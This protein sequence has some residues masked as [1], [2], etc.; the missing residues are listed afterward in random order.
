VITWTD[1]TGKTIAA[2]GLGTWAIGGPVAAGDDDLGWAEQR[3]LT[4]RPSY[5]QARTAALA[6]WWAPCSD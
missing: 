2:M 6:E 5:K 4:T 1:W 3:S